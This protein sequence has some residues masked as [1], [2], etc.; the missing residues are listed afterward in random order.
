VMHAG[1]MF[2]FTNGLPFIDVTTGGSGLE[3][4]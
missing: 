1:D 2:A 3:F 4:P